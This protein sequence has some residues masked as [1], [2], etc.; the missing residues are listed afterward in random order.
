VTHHLGEPP[1]LGLLS[2][3]NAS[4]A[5]VAFRA[6]RGEDASL[7]VA[8]IRPLAAIASADEHHSTPIYVASLLGGFLVGAFFMFFGVRKRRRL[9]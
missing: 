6:A 4:A 2:T 9:L 3:T 5:L 8:S 7:P 1:Q